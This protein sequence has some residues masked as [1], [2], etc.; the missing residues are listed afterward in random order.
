MHMSRLAFSLIALPFVC[1]L[2]AT[3]TLWAMRSRNPLVWMIAGALLGL[4]PYTYLSYP[5]FLIAAAATLAIFV[6]LKRNCLRHTLAQVGLFAFGLLF[7]MIPV[8]HPSLTDP[9]VLPS[10]ISQVLVFRSHEFPKTESFSKKAN[11]LAGRAWDSLTL[12]LRNPRRDGT[13]GTGGK[14]AVD[15][16]I[17]ILAYLG[18]AV[19]AIRWPQPSVSFRLAGG[20]WGFGGTG[21]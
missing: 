16:G 19:T 3:S 11:F 1:A 9:K 4:A 14:G 5:A 13:D 10:R 20:P 18:L 7:A 8:I 2:A 17:A 12:F 15:V 21:F 6:V